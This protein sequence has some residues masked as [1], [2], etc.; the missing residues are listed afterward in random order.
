[1]NDYWIAL[2]T[3]PHKERFVICEL[4]YREFE[5]LFPKIAVRIP[6]KK[7]R[8][9]PLISSYIFVKADDN[10]LE[11]LRFIPGSKGF[12]KTDDRPAIVTDDEIELML[13]ICG[14]FDIDND[15]SE[16]KC[17]DKVKILSGSLAGY[18]G[19]VISTDRKKLS[20]D[21]CNGTFR[22]IFNINDTVF[23]IIK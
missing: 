3:L 5:Y 11:K 2:R 21:L 20:I 6:G 18:D 23:E 12:L 13:K 1:M 14:E 10:D 9:K 15:I 22:V 4:E 7:K 16:F 8:T 17:G 19:F